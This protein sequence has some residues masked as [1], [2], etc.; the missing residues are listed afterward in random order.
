LYEKKVSEWEEESKIC[1][2]FRENW[3]KENTPQEPKKAEES[4]KLISE[5]I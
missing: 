4:G 1:A 3:I 2:Q 5:E